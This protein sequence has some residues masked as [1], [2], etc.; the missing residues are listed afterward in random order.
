MRDSPRF[1]A[2]MLVAATVLACIAPRAHAVTVGIGAYGG[3]SVSVIQQDN[4][5]GGIFGARLPVSLIPLFTIEPYFA[6]SSGGKLTK[7]FGDHSY[8]RSGFDQ[9]VFGANLLFG[10]AIAGRGI[11]FMNSL[12]ISSNKLTRAGSTDISEMG[13]SEGLGLGV[14]VTPEI[15]LIVRGDLSLVKTGETSRKFANATINLYYT[16]IHDKK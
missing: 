11:K 15:A 14:G 8:T 6:T 12:G 10:S 1:A 13:Y 4:K 16:L 3:T 9:K 7:V 5:G 2:T